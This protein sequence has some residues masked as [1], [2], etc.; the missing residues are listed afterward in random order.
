M[1]R[2]G[3]GRRSMTNLG[4]RPPVKLNYPQN[5]LLLG[6]VA[7]VDNRGVH[8]ALDS[9]YPLE[10]SLEVLDLPARPRLAALL[11]A[12]AGPAAVAPPRPFAV[13]YFRD[14]RGGP[15]DLI[16][17]TETVLHDE[18]PR[19]VT[20]LKMSCAT[21]ADRM[22]EIRV[23]LYDRRD[24]GDDLRD[25]RFLGVTD[26][27][28]DDILSESLLRREFPLR[29][30][31]HARGHEVGR[32]VLSA[33]VIRPIANDPCVVVDIEV[34]SSTKGYTKLFYVLSRQMRSGDFTPVYRSEALSRDAKRFQ[35]L[36]RSLG[37]LTAGVEDK[38]LR[39][40]LYQLSAR[41][42]HARIGF[43]KTSVAK[44]READV[45]TR[46]LWWPGQVRDG[47][48]DVGRVVLTFKDVCD[49]KLHF[50]FRFTQ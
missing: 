34:A 46:Q 47:V 27:R 21:L 26:C 9:Q 7:H 2:G 14:A 32:I 8:K 39:L 42:N 44:L 50:K 33:D 40:E 18:Y 37:A 17:R 22:K 48:I 15:W 11:I 43:L 4:A 1:G 5:R 10:V 49:D 16:G 36:A 12:A 35:P 24:H 20:K 41:G 29:S 23:V 3:D 25:Q 38:M 45:N 31:D 30:S 13:V 6:T 28:L 19:F